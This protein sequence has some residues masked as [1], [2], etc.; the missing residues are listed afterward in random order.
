MLK[1]PASSRASAPAATPETA[2]VRTAVTADALTKAS[3]S[4][5]SAL[6]SSTAPWW[7]SRPRAALPG[8]T[9]MAFRPKAGRAAEE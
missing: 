3:G 6:K 5:V 4:P 1:S 2:A 7:E 8:K 9:Q